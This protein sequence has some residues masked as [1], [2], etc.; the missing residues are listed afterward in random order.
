MKLAQ[1][2]EGFALRSSLGDEL[3]VRLVGADSE[4]REMVLEFGRYSG[5]GVAVLGP[6]LDLEVTFTDVRDRTS[7]R[8]WVEFW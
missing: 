2:V 7:L 8:G 1:D 4:R 3:A 6:P 5:E